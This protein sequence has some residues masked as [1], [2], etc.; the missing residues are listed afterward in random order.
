MKIFETAA[1]RGLVVLAAFILAIACTV[2]ASAQNLPPTWVFARS[3]NGWNILGQQANTYTFNSGVCNYTPATNGNEPSFFVFSGYQ[4]NISTTVPVY[5]PV[6][7]VDANTASSEIVTPTAT[8]QGSSSCGFA[9]ATTYTHTSFNLISG[10]AGLQEA[11]VSQQQSS[12]V[13]D[14]ILDKY[15]YQAVAALPTYPTTPN[16]QTIIAAV[17]GNANV[18]IVDTTT[19][20][21]T[22]YSWNGTKY[23]ADPPSGS[24]SFTSVTVVAAPT[25]LSTAAT[26][27]GIITTSATGGTIAAS[28]GTFRLGATYVTAR[29]ARQPSQ[30]TPLRRPQ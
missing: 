15:W 24:L 27:N 17:Q 26:V 10:T 28:A 23:V 11:I 1:R 4:T 13:F 19:M 7:I 29:A 12:P 5:F 14:V 8:Y 30:P 20:P 9:A 25:A 21:W 18:G 6:A 22:Y 16:A 3:Y 2:T